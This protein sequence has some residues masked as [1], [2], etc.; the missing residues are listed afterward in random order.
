V[1]PVV[2]RLMPQ[3]APQRAPAPQP[4]ERSSAA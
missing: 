4:A 1:L 3:P 2:L